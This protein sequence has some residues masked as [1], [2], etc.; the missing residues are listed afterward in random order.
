M[1]EVKPRAPDPDRVFPDEGA[2]PIMTVTFGLEL[3]IS[4][5][6]PELQFVVS[7]RGSGWDGW[8]LTKLV[9]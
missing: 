7:R 2:E 4:L 8:G 5:R 9:T 1:R 3:P 6:V